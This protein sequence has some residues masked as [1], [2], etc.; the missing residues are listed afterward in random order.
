MFDLDVMRQ[1]RRVKLAKKEVTSHFTDGW[2]DS[3]RYGQRAHCIKCD[4]WHTMWPFVIA[5]ETNVCKYFANTGCICKDCS[6]YA[7]N[8]RYV[9]ELSKLQALLDVEELG[10]ADYI[11]K[12]SVAQK[13][14][15]WKEF[16]ELKKQ[17]ADAYSL[18][19]TQRENLQ[20]TFDEDEDSN[21]FNSCI[22]RRVYMYEKEYDKKG[23]VINYVPKHTR[24][25]HCTEFAPMDDEQLCSHTNCVAYGANKKYYEVR[26]WVKRLEKQRDNFWQNKIEA[27]R[28]KVK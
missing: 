15:D 13:I 5:R 28:A 12:T 25:T 16:Q 24:P 11:C 4:R 18:L 6:G 23:K 3:K 1:K 27:L 26:M 19:K 21:A 22:K 10:W 7:A 17:L 20:H 8:Q 9:Q 14:Q 2:P